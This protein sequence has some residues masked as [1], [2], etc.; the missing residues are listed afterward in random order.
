M[1]ALRQRVARLEGERAAR[2]AAE[3][4]RCPRRRWNLLNAY[5]R[6]LAGQDIMPW[7]QRLAERPSSTARL[8]PRVFDTVTR[9]SMVLGLLCR[10]ARTSPEYRALLELAVQT[11]LA[12]DRQRGWMVAEGLLPPVCHSSAPGDIATPSI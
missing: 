5:V 3:Q 1:S 11:G 9:S 6:T 7:R 4:E 10:E 8:R 2:R 12:T